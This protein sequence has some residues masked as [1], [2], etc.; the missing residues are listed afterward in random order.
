MA[1]D[2]EI[3]EKYYHE[4][5]KNINQPVSAG[6]FA[7]NCVDDYKEKAKR[8][9]TEM[10]NAAKLDRLR[11]K[12]ERQTIMLARKNAALSKEKIVRN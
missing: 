1:K 4:I 9:K 3:L 10:R 7:A 2:I 6:V 11:Q 12:R 8:E 5:K